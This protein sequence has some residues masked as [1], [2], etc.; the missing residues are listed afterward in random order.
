MG[1]I[2]I[3]STELYNLSFQM[4]ELLLLLTGQ[5]VLGLLRLDLEAI[6]ARRLRSLFLVSLL[7]SVS[8]FLYLSRTIRLCKEGP[9]GLTPT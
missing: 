4:S 2:S 3:Q 7:P 9:G 1:T 6:H 5:A 8:C